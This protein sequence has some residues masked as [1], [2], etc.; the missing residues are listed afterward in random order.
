MRLPKALKIVTI[1]L[2]EAFIAFYEELQKR[3]IESLVR[4]LRW[5]FSQNYLA[6]KNLQLFLQKTTCQ[7]FD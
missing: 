3:W 2:S 4:Q 1:E 7:M 5:K 6:P